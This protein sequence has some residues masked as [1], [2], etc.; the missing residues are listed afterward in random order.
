VSQANAKTEIEQGTSLVVGRTGLVGDY[1]VEHLLRRGEQT[2]ALSRAQQGRPGVGWFRGDLENPDTLRFPA[3][4]TLY[5]T[6]DAV[7]G[8]RAPPA[9][10]PVIEANHRL[11]FDQR[12]YKTGYGG[13]RRAGNDKKTRRRLAKDH[14]GM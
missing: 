8:E 12:Y 1:I 5:C 10:Q 9:V 13:R 2:L 7:L 3:F 4:T 14:R 11:Q 6:A